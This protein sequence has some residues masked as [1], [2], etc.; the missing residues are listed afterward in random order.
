VSGTVFGVYSLGDGKGY[1]MAFSDHMSQSSVRC[2][3]TWFQFEH[4]SVPSFPALSL[5]AFQRIDA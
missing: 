4:H 3:L 1:I 2:L 5:P